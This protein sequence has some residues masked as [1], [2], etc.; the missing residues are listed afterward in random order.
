MRGRPKQFTPEE[1]R[2][3]T[4]NKNRIRMKQYYDEAKAVGLCVRMGC[5][6][7]VC[8]VRSVVCDEF[9][10][11]HHDENKPQVFCIKHFGMNRK[12]K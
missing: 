4:N 2:I 5:G 12:A 8:M 10:Y 11:V 6:R 9:G 3:R 1:Q 7:E